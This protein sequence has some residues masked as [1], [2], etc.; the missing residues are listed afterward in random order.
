MQQARR[1]KQGVAYGAKPGQRACK[2]KGRC[3]EKQG[4]QLDPAAQ[5]SCQ[6]DHDGDDNH[7]PRDQPLCGNRVNGVIAHN[8]NKRHVHKVLAESRQERAGVQNAKERQ[9]GLLFCGQGIW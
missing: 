6:G 5:E 9:G 2:E 8:G 3:G 1:K 7:V 4:A